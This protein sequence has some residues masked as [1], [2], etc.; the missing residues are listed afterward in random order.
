MILYMM[1][2]PSERA[3][4]SQAPGETRTTRGRASDST[5][6]ATQD[7]REAITQ[8]VHPHQDIVL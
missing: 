6:S 2:C 1:T 4:S 5:T 3:K 8:E 7:Y